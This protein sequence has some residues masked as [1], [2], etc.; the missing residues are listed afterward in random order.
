MWRAARCGWLLLLLA[1]V[2]CTKP[3]DYLAVAREQRQAYKEMADVLASID[4]EKSM[5]E[6][7]TALAEK[8]EK[9][10]VIAR[11]A[12]ALPAPSANVQER[13]QED[14]YAMRRAVERLQSEVARVRSLK[15][16]PEFFKQFESNHPSLFSA[17]QR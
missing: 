15:G 10:E 12:Q 1:L 7:K 13:L 8:S 9:F 11:K 14:A 4:D 2:G 6:A 3:E 17:V 16:G 5:A